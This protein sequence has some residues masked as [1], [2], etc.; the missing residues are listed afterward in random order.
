LKYNLEEIME[1]KHSYENGRYSVEYKGIGYDIA[2]DSDF[3]FEL[4]RYSKT[5]L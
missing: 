3:N 1:K 4:A 5:S 2:Y